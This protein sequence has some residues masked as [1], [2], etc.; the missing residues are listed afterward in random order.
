MDEGGGE[1]ES[2]RLAAAC[3]CKVGKEIE[4]GRDVG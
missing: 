3:I 4:N 1:G 2:V